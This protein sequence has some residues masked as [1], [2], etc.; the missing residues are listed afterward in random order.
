M[1]KTQKILHLTC[2]AC[3][4]TFQLLEIHEGG[5]HPCWEDCQSQW[6]TL[7]TKHYQECIILGLAQEEAKKEEGK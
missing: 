2:S 1:T 4:A 5:K 7:L 3:S 6:Q